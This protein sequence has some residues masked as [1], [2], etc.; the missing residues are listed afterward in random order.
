MPAYFEYVAAR[1]S[2]AHQPE[3][4]RELLDVLRSVL[5]CECDAGDREDLDPADVDEGEE[6]YRRTLASWDAVVHV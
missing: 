1:L 6:R 3:W 5:R 2:G 4:R